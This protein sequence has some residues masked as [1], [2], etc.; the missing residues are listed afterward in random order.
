V[1]S[2]E[3]AFTQPSGD[4]SI[5]GL[6]EEEL[7]IAWGAYIEKLREKNN[8]SGVSNFKSASLGILDQNNIIITTESKIHQ[9]FIENERAA[10]IEHLQKHFNNKQLAY[11]VVVEV[12]AGNKAQV[13][14]H[15]TIKEQYLKMIEDYPMVKQL[16]DRLKMELDY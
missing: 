2:G 16:K 4:K 15:L 8:H 13:E 10:L 1:R 11:K 6:N 14:K 9:A 7:Y 3:F 12:G 5:R